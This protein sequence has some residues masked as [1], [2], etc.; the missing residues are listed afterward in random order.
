M[1]KCIKYIV[2][3]LYLLYNYIPHSLYICV[4]IKLYLY[5]HYVVHIQNFQVII[6]IKSNIMVIFENMFAKC[7][8]GYSD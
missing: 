4:C 5:K 6:Y 1:F 8:F 7:E 3:L 2:S